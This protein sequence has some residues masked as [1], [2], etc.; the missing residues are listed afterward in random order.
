MPSCLPHCLW[1]GLCLWMM[2]LWD[3]NFIF[4]WLGE[5]GRRVVHTLEV[6]QLAYHQN[7]LSVQRQRKRLCLQFLLQMWRE[8]ATLANMRNSHN[9][10]IHPI[11]ASWSTTATT[12]HPHSIM[13][14]KHNCSI[15]K[16]IFTLSRIQQFKG[17]SLPCRN[18]E[19]FQKTPQLFITKTE[20]SHLINR[21]N[22]CG[23]F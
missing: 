11:I 15:S 20:S 17:I 5:F 6:P 1:S 2:G 8:L 10:P 18:E 7:S 14:H 19:I 21:L 16:V 9:H 22:G 13:M 23:V 12:V 4:Y 3:N